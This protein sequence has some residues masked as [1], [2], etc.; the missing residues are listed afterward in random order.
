VITLR[1]PLPSA[2]G[3][4]G[5][6]LLAVACGG[7]GGETA[8]AELDPAVAAELADHADLVADRLG[9]GD[10]CDA[11]EEAEALHARIRAGAEDGTI[12]AAVAREAEDVATDLTGQVSCDEDAGADDE[13]DGD[14]G[15][16][17]EQAETEPIPAQDDQGNRGD[18]GNDRDH[19]GK[20]KGNDNGKGKGRGR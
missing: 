9:A 20:G 3:L 6:A 13:E 5:V 14:E 19:P 8:T 10:H 18:G 16:D 1:S 11:L 2:A 4:V 15:A 12:P 7:D 17:D